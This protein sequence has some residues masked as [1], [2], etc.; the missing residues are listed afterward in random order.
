LFAPRDNN[1][2]GAPRHSKDFPPCSSLLC[3]DERTAFQIRFDPTRID[4]P[5]MIRLRIGKFCRRA[6]RQWE[7]ADHRPALLHDLVG[8]L[9]VSADRV[10]S[11]RSQ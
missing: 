6:S 2:I 4:Q 8:E 11:I 3:R 9:L 10:V 1:R 5:L 7:F